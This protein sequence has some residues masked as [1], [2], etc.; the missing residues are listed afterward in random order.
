[1]IYR[2]HCL[3]ERHQLMQDGKTVQV[4]DVQFTGLQRQLLALIGVSEDG[5]RLPR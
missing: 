2:N 5:F 3:A 4:F 1:M